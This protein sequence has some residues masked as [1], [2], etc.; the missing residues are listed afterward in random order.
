[1]TKIKSFPLILLSFVM[2]LSCKMQRPS[3]QKSSV[4]LADEYKLADSILQVG[5]DNEALF[6]LLGDIK[7]MSSLVSF[8]FP[9]ANTDSTKLLEENILETDSA[10]AYLA[11]IARIQR[12]VSSIDLD[13]LD[14]VF[15][16]YAAA[17][18]KTRSLQVS[19]VR[20]ALLDSLL[21]AKQTFFGQFGITPGASPVMVVTANEYG[22]KY[23]RLRGYGHLFGYPDYAVDFFVKAF[24]TADTD[25]KH[26]ER[27]F[28]RM[29]TFK[30]EEGNFVYAVPKGHRTN[31]VDSLI[32]KR[33]TNLLEEYK[34][35]RPR[36]LR[37]DSTLRSQELIR[38][39][40]K[41]QN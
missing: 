27:D 15:V 2:L 12:V 21:Y 10:Q 16:P 33:A 34:R 32:Y 18:G 13:G 9:I 29:P 31:E 11:E 7:P 19:V 5:L 39:F 38:D 30:S 1:M 17:Y 14:V 3:S 26:V 37:P 28:F 6:T 22:K 40:I 41:K 25:G 36:Y 35:W 24:H 4:Q 23:D 8:S 20:T